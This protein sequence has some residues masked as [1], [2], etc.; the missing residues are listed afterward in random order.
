MIIKYS[1]KVIFHFTKENKYISSTIDKEFSVDKPDYLLY[2]QYHTIGSGGPEYFLEH[3]Y[4]EL[5]ESINATDEELSVE[6]YQAVSHT[7]GVDIAFVNPNDTTFTPTPTL[8]I[9]IHPKKIE[10]IS[11]ELKAELIDNVAILWSWD[12]SNTTNCSYYLYDNKELIAQL[13]VGV[14]SYIES[15]LEYETNYTRHLVVFNGEE[16]S[17]NGNPVTITTGA[18]TPL[19]TLSPAIEYPKERFNNKI[20]S[21]IDKRIPFFKSGIGHGLDLKVEKQHSS[22][23]YDTYRL[24][25][26]AQ[27]DSIRTIDVY[28]KE[29]FK[30]KFY[31]T[32]EVP[33]LSKEAFA[34]ISYTYVKEGIIDLT[35]SALVYEQLTFSYRVCAEVKY[36]IVKLD[37]SIIDNYYNDLFMES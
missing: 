10:L 2:G 34:D 8:M 7:E 37:D 26:F 5:K 36:R 3:K 27:A 13:P 35:I 24:E 11:P 33:E 9:Y 17:N 28:N 6:E 12:T 20:H 1:L 29:S 14:S 18:K 25:S 16:Y 22:E 19:D 30:Y 21:I 23:Y 4:N 15:N 31:Y 32:A